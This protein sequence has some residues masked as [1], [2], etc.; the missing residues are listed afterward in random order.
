MSIIERGYLILAIL[1]KKSSVKRP[2]SYKEIQSELWINYNVKASH[3][4]IKNAVDELSLMLGI[5]EDDK[6]RVFIT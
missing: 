4:T 3:H 6:G 5:A 1:M 2:I